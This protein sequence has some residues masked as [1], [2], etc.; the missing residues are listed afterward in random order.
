MLRCTRLPLPALYLICVV[1][2]PSLCF[3]NIGAEWNPTGNPIGGGPGYSDSVSAWDYFVGTKDQLQNALN[4]ANSGDV[5]YVDDNAEI[6]LTGVM[7]NL[8]HGVTLASG[9]GRTMGDSISW[10][11]LLYCT[12]HVRSMELI[13]INGNYTRVT[14]LRLRGGF[15]QLEGLQVESDTFVQPLPVSYYGLYIDADTIEIDNCEIWG[16]PGAPIAGQNCYDVDLHHNYFHN[17]EHCY[18][19]YGIN[20][21]GETKYRNTANFTDY[22]QWLVMSGGGYCMPTR[23]YHSW[24]IFGHHTWGT[25][26]CSHTAYG[27]D[28]C[29]VDSIYNCS[30]YTTG[31]THD[32][33]SGFSLPHPARDTIV[34]RD[35]WFKNDSAKSVF[36]ASGAA[37]QLINNQYSAVT[38]PGV[39]NRI[40]VP[41]ITCDVDSGTAPLTVTFDASGSHDPDGQIIAYYWNFGDSLK[42]DNYS[43]HAD[44][45]TVS[46]TYNRI[47]RYLVE[48]MVVDNH[49]IMSYGYKTIVVVPN[50]NRAWLSCWIKDRHYDGYD[51]YYKKQV[52]IDNQVCWEKDLAGNGSWE[53]VIVDVQDL[54]SG[55]DSVTLAFKLQ[56]VAD[57]SV[58]YEPTMYVDDVIIFGANVVNGDFEGGPWTGNVYSR[59]DGYWQGSRGGTQYIYVIDFEMDVHSGE[60]AF[61]LGTGWH[62]HYQGD[63]GKVEQ[64]VDVVSVGI[65]PHEKSRICSLGCPYPN[66]SREASNIRYTLNTQSPVLMCIFDAAGRF[67]KSLVEQQQI[68]GAYSV[69]WDG[70]DRK[71]RAVPCGV[72]FCNLV[73]GDY[74]DTRQIVWLRQEY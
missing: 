61:Y 15:S 72:Y 50:D 36:I 37:A 17:G 40:P 27:Y 56:C 31:Y 18:H 24:C 44:S 68:P 33:R 64:K 26:F 54:L 74:E 65:I 70:T 9:R 19:A 11:G 67:V 4:S 8:N 48:L 57:K 25:S 55:K 32:H 58:Y 5:I 45:R 53:H 29:A 42:P 16:F 63:W 35:S 47:G 10:G 62:P 59:T 34:I 12:E 20:F 7:L 49:G 73:A 60:R 43:R 3:S 52:L 30:F 38:P 28:S 39:T 71:G 1:A 2:V 69:S 22:Q 21:W 51:G 6:D 14:G 23:G 41:S 46:H 66:P 13:R